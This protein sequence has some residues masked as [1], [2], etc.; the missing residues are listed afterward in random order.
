VHGDGGVAE[1]RLGTRRRHDDFAQRLVFKLVREG[2]DG[3]KLHFAVLAGNDELGA[4]FQVDVVHLDVG[5][6]RLQAAAPVHQAVIA[7]HEA[8]GV[9]AHESLLHGF[10]QHVIHREALA[11]PVKGRPEA[12]Q[13]VEDLA[14]VGVLVCF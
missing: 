7:V 9:H 13:L 14:A 12:A 10:G 11:G 6:G 5:D 4:A 2:P 8:L 3:P 1:H